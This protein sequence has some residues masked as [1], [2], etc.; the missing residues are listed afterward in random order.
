VPPTLLQGGGGDPHGQSC[1]LQ[2]WAVLGGSSVAPCSPGLS[3][4]LDQGLKRGYWRAANWHAGSAARN[5]RKLLL[6]D[7]WVMG[8]PARAEQQQGC[9]VPPMPRVGSAVRAFQLG[10]SCQD[11]VFSMQHRLGSSCQDLAFP[12]CTNRSCPFQFSLLLA[13]APTL[14][15]LKAPRPRPLVTSQDKPVSSPGLCFGGP[16]SDRELPKGFSPRP[17]GL[18]GLSFP[19]RMAE[20]W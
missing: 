16:F 4:G 1:S 20:R 10:S 3:S 9:S 14:Y 2:P 19:L 12:R 18:R 6:N 15:T 7:V 5:C 8:E 13:F 17:A 11:L